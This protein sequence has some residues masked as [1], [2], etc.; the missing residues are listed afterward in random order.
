M[1]K[2]NCIIL[3]F[4]I[5]LVSF[6]N[7]LSPA[8][9]KFITQNRSRLATLTEADLQAAGLSSNWI[10]CYG[11]PPGE[12]W[13]KNPRPGTLIRLKGN[14]LNLDTLLPEPQKE[15]AE[16]VLYQEFEAE[17]DGFAQLGIGCDWWF[18]VYCNGEL[19][20][21]TMERGNESERYVPYDHPFFFPVRKGKNLLAV[22]VKRGSLSWKFACSTIDFTLPE[23]PIV[24]VGPWLGDP[25]SDSVC[26]RFTTLGKVGAG[27]EYRELGKTESQIEWDHRQGR[28]LRRIFHA[29]RL[30]GLE[31]GKFYEYRIVLLDPRNPARRVYPAGDAWNEFQ[32]PETSVSEFSFFYTA[33][34]QHTPLTEQVRILDGLLKAADAASCDFFVFGGD[35]GNAFEPEKLVDGPIARICAHGGAERPLVMVRG[36]HELR[37]D[38]AERYLDYFANRD[39]HSYGIFRY[40]DTVFLVLDS[41]DDTPAEA[42]GAEYCKYNLDQWFEAEEKKFLEQAIQSPKW[43]TAKRRIV[44]SHGAPYSHYDHWKTMPPR[45]QRLTDIHFAGKNPKFRLDLWLAGHTHHYTRSIPGTS[46]IASP[47]RPEK[48]LKDGLE[49]CYP[50]LTVAGPKASQKFGASAFRV[51]VNSDGVQVCA[52]APDGTCFEKIRIADNGKVTELI[53]LPHFEL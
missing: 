41:W 52:F 21:S 33:D 29:S 19:C 31:A 8:T 14:R 35:I 23:L 40:G 3:L 13:M 12:N 47:S 30:T 46:I 4:S 48:P 51:D 6:A 34:L 18:E 39:G 26:I 2:N 53:S 1:K 11:P 16:A 15:G 38:D 45:L 42:K 10:F 5:Y 37:G 44:L 50:V 32:I 49:Y 17:G 36:N 28:I 43:T 24:T 9:E 7:A 22:R 27:I 20:Y 25:D